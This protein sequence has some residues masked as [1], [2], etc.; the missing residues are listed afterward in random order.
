MEGTLLSLSVC[1]SVCVCLHANPKHRVL[2]LRNNVGILLEVP[3]RMCRDTTGQSDY[4]ILLLVCI[5]VELLATIF[6]VSAASCDTMCG[7]ASEILSHF[8]CNDT[9]SNATCAINL[10]MHVQGFLAL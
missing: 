3:T 2:F 4:Y 8:A 7:M 6:L 10:H 1:V 9:P 5:H